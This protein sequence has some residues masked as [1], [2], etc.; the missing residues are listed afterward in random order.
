MTHNLKLHERHRLWADMRKTNSFGG[1]TRGWRDRL[2]V[3]VRVERPVGVV[4]FGGRGIISPLSATGKA[5]G[6]SLD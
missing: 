5:I 6:I 4:R 3:K 2:A 1:R